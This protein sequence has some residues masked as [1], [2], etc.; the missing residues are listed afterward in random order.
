MKNPL[1]Y[2]N[3]VST[4]RKLNRARLENR[5]A[6]KVWSDTA[7]LDKVRKKRWPYDLPEQSPTI[8]H[9][10]STAGS[11]LV[12]IIV[13]G[14]NGAHH[15]PALSESIKRQSHR[16]IEVIY[17]DNA[18][19][20]DSVTQVSALLPQAK[21]VQSQA[22]TGFAEGNNIGMDHAIGEYILLLN[23]D[24][25][26]DDR[27]I[28]YLLQ[29]MLADPEVGAVAPKIRF[30][31]RFVELS[32]KASLPDSAHLSLKVTESSTGYKK[33]IT[34]RTHEDRTQSFLIPESARHIELYAQSKGA[35][36]TDE[37]PQRLTSWSAKLGAVSIKEDGILPTEGSPA[38]QWIINNAG[39]WI[40]AI[41]D[42]GDWGFAEPDAGQFDTTCFVDAFC[43]CCALIRRSALG[44][45]PLFAPS[46]F[47]YYE[48]TDTSERIKANGFKIAYQP[49]A[50]AY[51]KHA[52]TSVEHSPFF[53]YFT[54]RNHSAFQ[55]AH[56]ES[57]FHQQKEQ[58]LQNW[59]KDGLL[60]LRSKDILGDNAYASDRTLLDDTLTITARAINRSIYTRQYA[61]KRIGIF[62]EYWTSLGG[63][64]LRALHIGLALLH[65]GDVYIISRQPI[66]L[67]KICGHFGLSSQGLKQAVIP[68]FG[69]KD[70]AY[71]DIFINTAFCSK[72]HSRAKKS[73]YLVSFPHMGGDASEMLSYDVLIANS[74]FTQ[75]WCHNYWPASTTDL[76]YPAVDVSSSTVTHPK[77]KII[78][79]VGR[80][81]F[82]GHNK[83]QAEMVTAFRELIQDARYADWR[84]VLI[85]GC[86]KAHSVD[87]DYLSRVQ[88]SAQGLPIDI[89]VDAPSQL[90][91]DYLNRA[92]I[93]WHATGVG[94]PDFYPEQFEHFG[95]AIVE[96]M[97]HAAV[98]I[99]HG[100]G[101]APEIVQNG[102]Y[103][104][105]FDTLDSLVEQ[106]S[107][108]MALQQT[109]PDE[110]MRL[111]QAARKR[112]M[113]FSLTAHNQR[114]N[115]I[116]DQYL[117]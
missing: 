7:Q 43:G 51:H 102:Q 114:L 104:F 33:V 85:G 62:N 9:N 37:P 60:H 24:A 92:A 73:A 13:V 69:E 38:G 97:S 30:W 82:S 15:V 77:E 48:D 55:A 95:M 109:Q 34:S 44:L 78:V 67:A 79:S 83:K 113:D 39:S 5:R 115:M 106:T 80:F 72:I 1:K 66:D 59:E 53:Q 98:P 22:N 14:Y 99:I 111:G 47:A 75:R 40:S 103:G 108:L 35:A 63:G 86:N 45:K 94:L 16:N 68:D 61:R 54:S 11:P 31:E 29:V 28:E 10:A 107:Q 18:S 65:I 42:A 88:A 52:S 17:V 58:R 8:A 23:N 32:V 50:V 4:I 81:F 71:L 20:D 112:S 25:R 26:L 105:C 12:S 6:R 57:V 117:S 41:G 64:E 101:G 90:V 89:F 21:I 91:E 49:A 87:Q 76:L 116:V 93:Y 96:A 84:L 27:A 3:I 36:N 100:R 70:T 110:F 56:F 46:F 19:S 74:I 2:K